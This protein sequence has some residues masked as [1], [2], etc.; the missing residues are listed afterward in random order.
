[1]SNGR[2][3]VRVEF[4]I[5]NNEGIVNML[6]ALSGSGEPD[7]SWVQSTLRA[8]GGVDKA[9]KIARSDTQIGANDVRSYVV[10]AE[11][12]RHSNEL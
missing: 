11:P 2:T 3:F 1:M 8:E 10:R 9:Y 4:L 12:R 5:G 7:P 6:P